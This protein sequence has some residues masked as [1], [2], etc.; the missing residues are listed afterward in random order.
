MWVRALLDH[1]AD[2]TIADKYGYTPLHDAC[3]GLQPEVVKLLIGASAQSLAVMTKD[4]RYPRDIAHTPEDAFAEDW[5]EED[6][7]DDDDED[8]DG[9]DDRGGTGTAKAGAANKGRESKV[10]AAP[11]GETD[12]TDLNSSVAGNQFSAFASK[13]GGRLRR[14]SVASSAEDDGGG[15]A[16]SGDLTSVNSE[17][18]SASADVSVANSEASSVDGAGSA[19]AGSSVGGASSADVSSA[20]AS[21]ADVSSADENSTDVPAVVVSPGQ[22]PATLPVG[23]PVEGTSSLPGT[24]RSGRKRAR[25]AGDTGDAG[26]HASQEED[27]EDEG[28]EDLD[29]PDRK[30]RQKLL[31]SVLKEAG[32]PRRRYM[33]VKNVL[34]LMFCSLFVF[35]V[36]FVLAT[37][38]VSRHP[39]GAVFPEM[40]RRL[41]DRPWTMWLISGL[42]FVLVVGGYIFLGVRVNHLT[43]E[44]IPASIATTMLF[45]FLLIGY[46]LW[47]EGRNGLFF[48]VQGTPLPTR[49]RFWGGKDDPPGFVFF[50][51][52][53]PLYVEN[54]LGIFLMV[55]HLWQ[56][57]G[58]TFFPDTRWV[59]T[60]RAAAMPL[61]FRFSYFDFNI[62]GGYK[63]QFF[64][65][66][67]LAVGFL[68]LASYITISLRVSLARDNKENGIWGFIS[69]RAAWVGSDFLGKLPLATSIVPLLAGPGVNVVVN[70]II[71][72]KKNFLFVLNSSVLFLF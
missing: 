36:P 37:S 20:D 54:I 60:S 49:V 35:A 25:K 32:A 62:P 24:T 3:A 13:H 66:V 27:E 56:G 2:A 43:E 16:S 61:F 64:I 58:L 21:L 31:K 67:A 53:I 17:A 69:R 10:S 44:V 68:I 41:R 45:V 15:E 65:A 52:E 63:L 9:D 33:F 70:G 40:Q 26:D 59:I 51:L 12:T 38:L 50:G 55:L 11:G 34:Y 1:G 57:I 29:E 8:D 48:K 42:L 39:L 28:M 4:G 23:G 30:Q 7:D 19:D 5:D 18:A 6:D 14:G 47:R 71:C 22:G 72:E 46:R